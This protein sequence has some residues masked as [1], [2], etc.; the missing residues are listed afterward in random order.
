M[1]IPL[2]M[3]GDPI[4]RHRKL[5]RKA[6]FLLLPVRPHHGRQ[7]AP[8]L[9]ATPDKDAKAQRKER[10]RIH[11]KNVCTKTRSMRRGLRGLSQ[12]YAPTPCR[13]LKLCAFASLREIFLFIPPER[14]AKLAVRIGSHLRDTL[15]FS[16]PQR[17]RSTPHL[18]RRRP[19]EGGS[20]AVLHKT[21]Q[22]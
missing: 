4:S 16:R 8:S 7:V 11:R 10:V 9:F 13:F 6:D 17:P 1:S 3:L 22:I 5:S 14:H 21:R 20:E 18:S 12:N 15:S 19:C 2:K